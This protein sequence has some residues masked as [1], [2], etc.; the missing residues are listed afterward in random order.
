MNF[1]AIKEGFRTYLEQKQA[2]KTGE[3]VPFD[4]NKKISIFAHSTEFKDYLI[5]EKI[6]DTT[7]SNK[8]LNE[9]LSMQLKDGK[10]VEKEEEPKEDNALE[11]NNQAEGNNELPEDE[12]EDLMTAL[13][14]DMLQ[15]EQV[16]SALDGDFS[17]EL[18]VDEIQGYLTGIADEQGEIS[19]D[20]LAQSV[21]NI[22][23]TEGYKDEMYEDADVISAIDTDGDGYLSDSEKAQFEGFLK[24]DKDYVSLEDL[25]N[26]YSAIKDGTFE[27]FISTDG[28]KDIDEEIPETEAKEDNKTKD[29]QNAS[30]QGSVSYPAGNTGSGY[31]R[32]STVKEKSLDEKTY[33]EMSLTELETVK[34]KK[35]KAVSDARENLAKIEQGQDIDIQSAQAKCDS[36]R[37]KYLKAVET[38]KKIDGT[39]KTNISDTESAISDKEAEIISQNQLIDAQ[40]TLIYNQNAV[41]ESDKATLSGL[42]AAL[43]NLPDTSKYEND[44]EKKALIQTKKTELEGA[45]ED[46]KQ[47][48]SDDEKQLNKT[49]NPKLEELKNNLNDL[50]NKDLKE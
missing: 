29:A 47:K 19:F 16:I 26:A 14:N 28:L 45:I 38:D 37:E 31:G 6:A 1:E 18:D 4:E 23:L 46:A 15:D 20:N 27:Y 32:T 36:A 2:E 11:D 3:Y 34:P 35:E 22:Y 43:N 5:S 49:L 48:V 9:I 13:I 30:S 17:G 40:N 12:P 39:L 7:I 50:E 41:I 10:L 8:S 33:E 25:E 21:Q 24:G 42:E 44:A